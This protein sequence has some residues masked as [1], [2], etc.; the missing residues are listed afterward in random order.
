MLWPRAVAGRS[1]I[2]SLK[3]WIYYG[4]W[5]LWAGATIS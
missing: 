4:Q 3:G 1:A 2:E 5:Y